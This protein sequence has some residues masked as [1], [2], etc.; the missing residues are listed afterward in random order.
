LES[1]SQDLAGQ[2]WQT[3]VGTWALDASHPLLPGEQI[4][5]EMS[6][7]WLG[8]CRLLIQHSHYEHPEIPDAIAIFGVI[9]EELS[10]HY[11]DSRGVHRIFTVSMT[12]RTLG[13]ARNAPGFSQRFTLAISDDGDTIVGQGEL[14]RDGSSWQ[15][16]LAITYRRLR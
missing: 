2:E 8:G 7:E 16:D 6:F 13:Y 1:K 10:M 11:F 14:S 3:L 9:D 4:R 12:D 5:G 15:D